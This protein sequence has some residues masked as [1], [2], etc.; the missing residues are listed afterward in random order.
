MTQQATNDSTPRIQVRQK[1]QTPPVGFIGAGKVARVLVTS[2]SLAGYAVT[3]VASRTF[4]SA[5]AL[6]A[7][8]PNC[9]AY[10]DVQEVANKCE[11]VFITTPD[12]DIKTVVSRLKW[13][14]GQAAVHCSG[15]DS[16]SLLTAA[17]DQGAMTGVFHPLQTI[18]KGTHSSSLLQDITFT[19]EATGMLLTRL[20][21]MARAL[22]GHWIVLRPEDKALYHASAVI[23]SNYMVTLAGA[24][25]IMWTKFGISPKDATSALLPLM[26]GTL[27]NIGRIG[28][29]DCLTGP[30]ARGDAGTVRRHLKA[31][32]TH[33]PDIEAAYRELGRLTLP[34]GRAAGKL[35]DTTVDSLTKALTE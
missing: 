3:S 7:R 34:L 6:A 26:K 4:S 16:A 18:A 19:I 30:I 8:I 35:D 13:H 31:I 14:R 10:R 21:A 33:V 24:A 23:A 2:L 12:D 11:F 28:L 1:K 5:K 17:S 27:T 9:T 29:P 32:H 15:A 25:V 22:G 20:K